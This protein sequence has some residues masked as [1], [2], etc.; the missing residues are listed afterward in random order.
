ML[1]DHDASDQGTCKNDISMLVTC[2]ARTTLCA[3]LCTP[4]QWALTLHIRPSPSHH[5]RCVNLCSLCSKSGFARQTSKVARYKALMVED[6]FSKLFAVCF[7]LST[8]TLSLTEH[9][10]GL[11]VSQYRV[12]VCPPLQG[13]IQLFGF[14]AS[15][16]Q[17]LMIAS[18]AFKHTY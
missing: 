17:S 13:H 6:G 11:E 9:L 15:N 18:I 14:V 10:Q 3:S 1:A 2:S 8:S 5:D 4:M 7:K 12:L 16:E